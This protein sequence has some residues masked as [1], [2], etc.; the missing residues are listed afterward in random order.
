MRNL[1]DWTTTGSVS[2]KQKARLQ[3]EDYLRVRGT[4]Q[5]PDPPRGIFLQSGPQGFLVSWSLPANFSDIVGWRIYKDDET[6]L[7][8]EIR[9]RGIRQK[10]VNSTAGATPPVVN[11]FVSSVNALGV[12]SA[13]IQAQGS[14]SADAAATVPMPATRST[15]TGS[16]TSSSYQPRNF[17]TNRP[18]AGQGR[19]NSKQ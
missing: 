14:A 8:Q 4:K 1:T 15:T 12:E 10:F 3:S 6:S 13:K 18:D 5:I 19:I 11:I 7:F 9:D 16:N 2:Q 17:S